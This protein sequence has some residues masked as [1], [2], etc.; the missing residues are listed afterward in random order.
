MAALLFA[1]PAAAASSFILLSCQVFVISW[2]R[3]CVE[4]TLVSSPL[5]KPPFCA[6][7]Q[8][9]KTM[10]SSFHKDL[11]QEVRQNQAFKRSSAVAF[12]TP[13]TWLWTNHDKSLKLRTLSQATNLPKA[14]MS[15]LEHA[16]GI[17]QS[18]SL[19]VLHDSSLHPGSFWQGSEGLDHSAKEPP[20]VRP[21]MAGW[22]L[23]LGLTLASAFAYSSTGAWQSHETAECLTNLTKHSY[24][25]CCST[26]YWRAA[27]VAAATYAAHRRPNI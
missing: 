8:H 18:R 20:W 17:P 10:K 13:R 2:H 22:C 7:Y 25:S 19:V 21:E 1:F 27:V 15:G 3:W 5:I 4:V 11:P 9:H 14:L 24:N 6:L 12:G 16:L 23:D 26:R